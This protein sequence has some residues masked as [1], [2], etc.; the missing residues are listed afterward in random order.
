MTYPI[1][2]LGPTGYTGLELIEIVA[3]HPSMRIEYLASARTPEPRIDA[4]FPRLVGRLGGATAQCKP[5]SHDAIAEACKG[6]IAFLCLPHEA[7]MQHTPELLARGLKVVDLSAAYRIKDRAVYEKTYGHPHTDPRNLDSAVYG[8]TEFARDQVRQARLVANPGCYPTAAAI[9]LLPLL[10][11]GM[12]DPGSI[13]IDA[14]SGVSGAGREPKPH[15]T[16]AEAG[17]NYSAYGIGTHR[18]QP[19]INQTLRVHGRYQ[20]P[21]ASTQAEALFVPHLLPVERGILETIYATPSEKSLTSIQVAEVLTRAYADEPF[22]TVRK[23]SPSLRDVN[24]TNKVHVNGRVVGGRVVLVAAID[25][26]VKGAS[27][28]A[29]Q[30]ANLMLGIEETAGL[31]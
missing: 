1:A 21:H 24:R 7:A 15:T 28:Q 22:V 29:V 16:L 10:R 11:A 3:R 19:E 4:E 20:S 5:L 23:D 9:A 18:H 6:G 27:G 25:N 31:L 30:N 8:L 14:A 13:I 17:E 26:L 2:I 12:I